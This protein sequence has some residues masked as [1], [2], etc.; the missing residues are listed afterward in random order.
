MRKTAFY[1]FISASLLYQGAFSVVAQT[2]QVSRTTTQTIDGHQIIVTV[3]PKGTLRQGADDDW[4]T[5]GNTSDSTYFFSLD[6]PD[7]VRFALSFNPAKSGRQV[8]LIYARKSQSPLPTR[9][10]GGRTELGDASQYPH[11]VI[12]TPANDWV[13]SGKANYQLK[14]VGD[15]VANLESITSIPDGTPDFLR[16]VTPDLNGWPVR[17]EATV[18]QNPFVHRGYPRYSLAQ[19]AAPGAA[20]QTWPALMPT[21]PYLGAGQKRADWFTSNPNPIYFNVSSGEIQFFPFTGFQTAGMYGINSISV[22]SKDFENAF[23]FY[24]LRGAPPYADLV[25]RSKSFPAGD[26][27]GPKPNTMARTTFRYSWKTEDPT[28]W[29]YSLGFVG[30][31]IIVENNSNKVTIDKEYKSLSGKVIGAKWNGISFI[32]SMNGFSGSEGIYHYSM[33]DDKVWQEFQNNPP[34][35]FVLSNPIFQNDAR[36]GPDA[37]HTIPL[38]FRGEYLFDAPHNV[39]LYRSG[40]DSL[41]HLKGAREGF[42][43]TKPT[44]YL[45]FTDLNKDG[46]VDSF[47]N[48]AVKNTNTDPKQSSEPSS[49]KTT[50]KVCDSQF[51]RLGGSAVLINAGEILVKTNLNRPV[52]V[53]VPIPLATESWK[54]FLVQAGQ[55]KSTADN[56]KAIWDT[57][58]GAEK[59]VS[60]RSVSSLSFDIKNRLLILALRPVSG[61]P[62]K[63]VISDDGSAMLK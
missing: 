40:I 2:P 46:Y 61:Q 13:I 10:I 4:W 49:L 19:R 60:Q 39:S 41:V 37:E 62:N 57:V 21:F 36:L 43:Y 45:Y 24:S 52:N 22:E 23:A 53:A 29:T 63:L 51:I 14:L 56:V 15:G 16:V 50:E 27:F 18:T 6:R 3:T 48:C 7:N 58:I 28:L 26:E 1:G 54:S 59:M 5:W 31:N 9:Q 17:D 8:T 33:Q 38:N 35:D 34:K 55:T 30:Q 32:Q 47:Q 25:I 42:W 20:F 11:L 44:R 12:S